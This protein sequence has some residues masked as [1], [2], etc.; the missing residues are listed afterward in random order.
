MPSSVTSP[1][2]SLQARYQQAQDLVQGILTRKVVCNDGVF[3]H[4]LPSAQSSSVFWYLHETP[5]GKE[6]RQVD[7]STGKVETID[8]PPEPATAAPDGLSPDG[9][10]QVFTRD[11]NLWLRNLSSGEERALTDDGSADYAYAPNRPLIQALWSPDGQQLF[12]YRFDVRQVTERPLVDHVPQ[13]GSIATG[14]TSLKM[15]YPGDKHIESYEL[16]SIDI[17]TGQQQPANYRVPQWRQ[18]AGYLTTERLGWW[19]KDSQRAYFVNINRNA[20]AAQVIEF[21]TRSGETRVM[22]EET[23]DT[24]ISLSNNDGLPAIH[25]LPDNNELIWFSE[26]SGW[27]H[28]YLYDLNSGELTKAITEGPWLL[29]NILHVDSK[30]RELILQTGG[31]DSAISPH[32]R[33]IVKVHIDTGELTPLATGNYEHSVFGARNGRQAGARG[34]LGVDQPGAEGVSPDGQYLVYT[35]SRVDTPPVS[36]LIDRDGN[37]IL[38]LETANPHGLPDNW[39]WPEP[40]KTQAADGKTDIYGVVYWPPGADKTGA[41]Q[42]R[43]PVLDFSC[44]QPGFTMVPQGSFINGP[45]FDYPY[46]YAAAFAALGFVVVA[47]EGRGMPNRH[48][49]FHDHCYGAMASACELQDRIA[50]IQQLAETYPCMDT[51][52]VG[53]VGGDGFSSPVYGLLKH[54]DFYQVGVSMAFEDAR[55]KGAGA[56]EWFEPHWLDQSLPSPTYAEELAANLKGKLLLIHG[57]MDMFAPQSGSLRLVNAIQAANRDVDLML[58][59]QVGHDIPAYALR[60]TWDYLV[61]HLL[62]ETP[63]AHYELQTGLDLLMA[64]L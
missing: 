2:P 22:F 27:G 20:S 47:L 52:R 1:M 4:W 8:S 26:R 55:L 35:R 48:K 6:Y 49:A 51:Q 42:H 23:S 11:H 40:V 16:L 18:G 32:Y 13:D 21:N 10:Q 56:A 63:P 53:I 59:P 5:T 29:R 44:G 30:R 7:A 39:V 41:D 43:Y 9:Q 37:E 3:P 64:E 54:A 62:G 31:R 24:F 12:T 45:C 38:S 46:L 61:T 14:L 17:A 25:Y 58:M 57:L 34:G 15:A 33:D 28:L 60:R 36:V 19:A 50:G